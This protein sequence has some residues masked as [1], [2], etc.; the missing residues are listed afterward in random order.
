MKIILTTLGVVLALV[1]C[2][3]S[4]TQVSMDTASKFTEGVTTEKE[5]VSI[6]GNPTATTMAGGLRT[7]TYSGAQCQTKAA[8]FVPVVGMFAG[9]M[10]CQSSAVVITLDKSGI[11]QKIVYSGRTFGSK[12]GATPASQTTIDPVAK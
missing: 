3:S 9:G 5:I 12:N 8:T 11:A 4:G 6:L 10:D 7:I 2:A 1:G